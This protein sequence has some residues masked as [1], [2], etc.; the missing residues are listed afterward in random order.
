MDCPYCKKEMQK[1][2]IMSGT[3]IRW[4]PEEVKTPMFA[5]LEESVRLHI[6]GWV[7]SARAESWYCADC[8][9]VITPVPE[10]EEPLSKLKE[11][12]NAFADRVGEET[13]KRRAEREEEQLRKENEARRKKDPWEV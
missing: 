13:E 12:W 7:D 9:T 5:E 4:Y 2:N 3:Q 10:I 6:G 8:R 11:K 1:G